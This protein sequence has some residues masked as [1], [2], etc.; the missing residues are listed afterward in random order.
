[1]EIPAKENE[2][3]YKIAIKMQDWEDMVATAVTEEFKDVR[4]IT[5]VRALK[6]RGTW[7]K[8]IEEDIQEFEKT[9]F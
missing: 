2:N 9:D 1:M 8:S 3:K 5:H 6:L 4:N 7:I